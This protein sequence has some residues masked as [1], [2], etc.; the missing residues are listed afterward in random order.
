MFEKST[1]ARTAA[2]IANMSGWTLC[3]VHIGGR[4]GRELPP[5][6]PSEMVAFALDW[7][8]NLYGRV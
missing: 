7:L 5:R 6:A 1:G 8:D 4:F 3:T 2:L